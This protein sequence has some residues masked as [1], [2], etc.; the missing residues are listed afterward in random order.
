[1]KKEW[2]SFREEVVWGSGKGVWQ[3]VYSR[4]GRLKFGSLLRVFLRRL[5]EL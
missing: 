4:W 1:M 3:L 5:G 2:D